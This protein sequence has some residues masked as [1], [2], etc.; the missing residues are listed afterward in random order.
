[1]PPASRGIERLC[2]NLPSRRSTQ[3]L[4]LPAAQ[5]IQLAITMDLRFRDRLT[6]RFNCANA[7]IT[8]DPECM[9]G[10]T[11]LQRIERSQDRIGGA[12]RGGA[13]RGVAGSPGADRL[14]HVSTIVISR[15]GDVLEKTSG[16]ELLVERSLRSFGSNPAVRGAGVRSFVCGA[17]LLRASHA[18]TILAAAL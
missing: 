6:V 4:P 17:N 5:T 8:I 16:E 12:G 13:G 3:N 10:L 14:Y 18:F 9:M 2:F 1:M 7:I 15:H 11:R